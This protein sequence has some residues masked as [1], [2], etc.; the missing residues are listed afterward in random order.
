MPAA[1][2]KAAIADGLRAVQKRFPELDIGSYP[3]YR[4]SGNGVALVAKGTDAARLDQ[5]LA[6]MTALIREVGLEPVAG[7]PA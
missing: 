3:Y 7:E 6:E 5:A 1:C 4:E 2:W